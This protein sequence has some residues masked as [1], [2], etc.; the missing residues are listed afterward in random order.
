MNKYSIDASRELN[1]EKALRLIKELNRWERGV[2]SNITSGGVAIYPESDRQ[3][4]IMF[5]VC[6]KFGVRRP[7]KG[8]TS[9]ET[10]VIYR[11]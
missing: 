5:N 8:L 3:K 7:L 10:D 6:E 11:A 1:Y 9:H 4:K 2:I